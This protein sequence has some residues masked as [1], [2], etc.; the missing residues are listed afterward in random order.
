MTSVC[1]HPNFQACV[2]VNR[3]TAS[4]TDETVVAFNADVR[5][6]CA[7]CSK[8][9][10]FIGVPIGLLHTEPTCSVDGTQ[11]RMPIKPVGEPMRADL[12]GFALRVVE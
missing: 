11:A 4:E 5:I 8:P 7:E 2:T 10:E 6:Q 9:F 12:A 3:L 1:L